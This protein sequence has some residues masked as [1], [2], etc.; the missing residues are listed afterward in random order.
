[1]GHGGLHSGAR[2]NSKLEITTQMI[3]C[4]FREPIVREA[5]ETVSQRTPI[6]RTH[7]NLCVKMC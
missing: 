7:T 5:N 2:R 4:W 3:F 6:S 1:M